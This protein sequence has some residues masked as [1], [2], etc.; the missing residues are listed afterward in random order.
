MLSL[1]QQANESLP[2]ESP[3][4]RFRVGAKGYGF[5]ILPAIQTTGV[6]FGATPINPR[7]T[8]TPGEYPCKVQFSYGSKPDL[9]VTG[10]DSHYFES[11]FDGFSVTGLEP[12][13][14]WRVVVFE[15]PR[16]YMVRAPNRPLLGSTLLSSVAV[17]VDASASQRFGFAVG[18]GSYP[19]TVFRIRSCYR[20]LNFFFG[21]VSSTVSIYASDLAAT[22]G[23][24][25][26]ETIDT[27]TNTVAGRVV[28][29]PAGFMCITAL[30]SGVYVSVEALVE[31]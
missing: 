12:N 19:A 28:N 2:E 7:V 16:E 14:T 20:A 22:S 9:I 21:G 6:I 3:L 15:S 29:F 17:P 24:N 23:F 13:S 25:R 18:L 26:S 1:Y 30:V 11:P 5:A 27:S 31:L 10:P 4:S 8:G